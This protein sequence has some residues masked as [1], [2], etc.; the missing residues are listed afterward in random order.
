MRNLPG[1]LPRSAAAI[2]C[3]IVGLVCSYTRRWKRRC[4]GVYRSLPG[5]RNTLI[6]K[7]RKR[8]QPVEKPLYAPFEHP[9]KTQQ[10]RQSSVS[11]LISKCLERFWTAHLSYADFFNRLAIPTHF[12]NKGYRRK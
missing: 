7:V 12:V 8:G 4:S 3:I 1:F 9:S 10:P 5:K 2:R 11:A 6:H